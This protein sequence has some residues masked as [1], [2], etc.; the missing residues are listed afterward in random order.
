MLNS[1]HCPTTHC[2]QVLPHM[3]VV[4][5]RAWGPTQTAINLHDLS[6]YSSQLVLMNVLQQR[7]KAFNPKAPPEPLQV[8]HDVMHRLQPTSGCNRW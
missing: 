1:A 5:P 3:E 8:W 7:L 6:H 4:Q 2:A